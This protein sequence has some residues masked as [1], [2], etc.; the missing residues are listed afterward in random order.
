MKIETLTYSAGDTTFHG[1]LADP[2]GSGRRPG[3]VIVHG[4]PGLNDHPKRR[5]RM[6]AEL[7]YVALAVDMY[8]GGRTAQKPED[9]MNLM[10]AL[11]ATFAPSPCELCHRDAGPCRC[12]P[13]K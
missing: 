6:I 3:V 8:G 10:A 7:G 1:Y 4:A 12:G 9:S 2:E 5:A 11:R 13:S